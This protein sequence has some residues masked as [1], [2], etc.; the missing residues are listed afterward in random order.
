MMRFRCYTLALLLTPALLPAQDAHTT[1]AAALHRTW[2]AT[3]EVTGHLDIGAAVTTLSHRSGYTHVQTAAGAK[4]WVYSR[5]LAQ[6]SAPI[7]PPA[8]P[9]PGIPPLSDI[10]S[11][12]KPP[13]QEAGLAA[14]ADVG[15]GTQRLDS[16][17]NLL[18][19]RVDENT[20]NEV[21]VAAVLALPWQ[22]MKTRRYLW[23]PDDSTRT[24]AYEGAPISVTGFIFDVQKEDPEATNCGKDPEEWHDWH[25][26]VVE[27]A[28]EVNDNN[29]RKSIVVEITPRV[30]MKFPGRFDIDQIR[31]WRTDRQRVVVA[32]WLMLDP[33]HPSH[34]TGTAN[35]APSRGTIWEIHPVMNITPQP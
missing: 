22:G 8:P 5:W 35:N 27:T 15:M 3:S 29:K 9:A 21:S 17:T 19:N 10:E 33:D 24:A 2:A 31:Q 14:C 34:A 23:D 18:K 7:T 13:A 28:A 26:W 32:G 30:R 11:L 12:P 4:G 1:H 16:A 6:G 20:W 25:M